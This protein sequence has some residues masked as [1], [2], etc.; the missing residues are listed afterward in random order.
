MKRNI[1]K[2]TK[3]KDLFNQVTLLIQEIS[4]LVNQWD[5][6]VILGKVEL[7]P[8]ISELLTL[9]E[10]EFV[11]FDIKRDYKWLKNQS[12]IEFYERFERLKIASHIDAKT[13]DLST[14]GNLKKRHELNALNKILTSY[15][16]STCI[17]FG[18]G[19]GNLAQHLEHNYLM[20]VTVLEQ[21]LNLIKKG[22][23][24]LKK[25]H[26]KVDFI[27]QKIEKHTVLELKD[28]FTL[29]I[30]LHTCGSF[31]NHMLK[32][33]SKNKVKNIINFGCCYSKL[34]TGDYNISKDANKSIFLNSRAL[35]LATLSFTP[36]EEW[37]A[38]YRYQIMDYKYTWYHYNYVYHNHLKF[39]PMSNARRSVYQQ[40]IT[41]FFHHSHQK[42]TPELTGAKDSDILTFYQSKINQDLLKYF[43]CYYALGRY[44]GEIIEYYLLLDRSL[45]LMEQGYNVELINVFNPKISPRNK[46]IIASLSKS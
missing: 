33:T 23:I 25:V 19:V 11:L 15:K 46:M 22:E 7:H 26:S 21:N 16:H 20:D 35:S 24:K 5:E 44:L 43:K 38:K 37:I 30:G 1:I 28:K 27:H 12:W 18:G 4:P 34:E 14:F 17:D 9:S 32:Q 8:W 40:D 42:F 3:L 45:F 2:N 31:A 39:Y 10:K 29:A 41:D 36:A 13:A 6:D